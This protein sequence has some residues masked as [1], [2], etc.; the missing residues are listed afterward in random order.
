MSTIR[1]TIS[2][3]FGR[4][5]KKSSSS[6]HGIT[7]TIKDFAIKVEIN[8]VTENDYKE[9]IKYFLDR[10]I[11]RGNKEKAMKELKTALIHHYNIRGKQIPIRLKQR[12][13]METSGSKIKSS[14]SGGKRRSNKKKSKYHKKTCKNRK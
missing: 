5:A 6:P 9:L 14:V 13:D 12:L 2:S 4:T 7:K 3:M 11:N 1:S 10:P 8:D